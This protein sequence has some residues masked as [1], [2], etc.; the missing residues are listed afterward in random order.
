MTLLEISEF[1]VKLIRT[2]IS[3]EVKFTHSQVNSNFFVSVSSE[4]LGMS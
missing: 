3:L 4:V 2:S 1:F